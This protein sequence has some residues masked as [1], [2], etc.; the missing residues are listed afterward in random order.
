[1][2]TTTNYGWTTPNDTDLVKNGASAIRTFGSGVDTTLGTA[3]NNKLHAGLV[4][5]KTQTIGTAV[6]SVTVTNAFSATYDNYKIIISGG[7]LSTGGDVY[8][9]LGTSSTQYN[10][11]MTY[12]NFTASTVLGAN[13]NN[14]SQF[15]YAGGGDNNA[16][17]MN[18]DLLAP[19]KA[20]F[21]RYMGG[22]WTGTNGSGSS[23]GT[24]K[25]ATS[26]TDFTILAGAGTL[27]GG[28]I[29]VYGYAKD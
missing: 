12:G 15:A 4:L 20:Q 6:T 3:L 1:M 13:V 17:F 11:F 27:T 22:A 26:Y 21:T 25:L 14:G 10:E 23:S 28:T 24:H 19:F 7:I 8:L 5:V 18:V 29:A 2:A 16:A 9:R